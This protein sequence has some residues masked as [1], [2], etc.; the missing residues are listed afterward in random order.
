M[1]KRNKKKKYRIDGSSHLFPIPGTVG[2]ECEHNQ[3]FCKQLT[4]DQFKQMHGETEQWGTEI[5]YVLLSV[6]N[7]AK[8]YGKICRSRMGFYKICR[9]CGAMCTLDGEKGVAAPTWEPAT[10]V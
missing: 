4:S 6:T 1:K 9:K 5:R 3:R 7:L 2:N 10:S 8:L